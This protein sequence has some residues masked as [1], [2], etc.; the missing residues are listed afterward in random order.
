MA[1]DKHITP[2]LKTA[3][4]EDKLPQSSLT[5]N[6]TES[7]KGYDPARDLG[8]SAGLFRENVAS[9]EETVST[10]ESDLTPVKE[11]AMRRIWHWKPSATRY[12]ADDPP[13]FTVWLNILFAL[14]S[15]GP[16]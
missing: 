4:A 8:G 9:D 2:T 11:G 12:D 16:K 10:A 14:V 6:Q 15:L 5:E 1:S 3:S 13:K 7:E